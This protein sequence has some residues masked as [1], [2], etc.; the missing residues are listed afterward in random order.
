MGV[1]AGK[2][3]GLIR[4][5]NQELKEQGYLIISGKIPTAYFA[6]KYYGFKEDVG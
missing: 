5:M 3:Y 2:A 6:K 1:S 4:E